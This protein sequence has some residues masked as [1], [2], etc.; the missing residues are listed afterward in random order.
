M[1]TYTKE[2]V[3]NFLHQ[4]GFDL[5]VLNEND[6]TF[7]MHANEY[8]FTRNGNVWEK[9]VDVTIYS[10]DEMRDMLVDEYGF[11]P[12]AVEDDDDVCMYAEEHG[13]EEISNNHFK[14]A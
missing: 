11:D 4:T 1:K 8:G 13:Y 14:E 2:E 3:Q 9:E 5:D 7:E 12:E 6:S 10:L